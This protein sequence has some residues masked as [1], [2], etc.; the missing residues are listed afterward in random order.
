[1]GRLNLHYKDGGSVPDGVGLL[2]SIL[3]RYPEVCSVRY[4]QTEHGLTFRFMIYGTDQGEKFVH[5]LREALVVYHGLEGKEMSICEIQL[6]QEEALALITV[7]RDVES[8]DQRE[9]GLIV[10]LVKDLSQ[11][12]IYD[13]TEIPEEEQIFQEEVIGQT[14]QAFR[15]RRLDKGFI[16]IREE[17]RVLVYNS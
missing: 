5:S 13:D 1:M 10:D 9:V 3:V 11:K 14:L 7:T 8:M 6:K 12:L 15:D 16:A 2:I 4:L 17:G